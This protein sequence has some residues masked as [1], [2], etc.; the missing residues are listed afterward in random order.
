VDLV[1]GALPEPVI[2]G[3]KEMDYYRRLRTGYR[4]SMATPDKPRPI[5][6]CG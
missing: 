3:G 4:W 5:P 2:T 6:E 1:F